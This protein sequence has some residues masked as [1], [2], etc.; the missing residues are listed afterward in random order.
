MQDSL[1]KLSCDLVAIEP[2]GRPDRPSL[3]EEP[4]LNGICMTTQ[5]RAVIEMM[6]NAGEHLDATRF[7]NLRDDANHIDRATVYR[8][9]ELPKTFAADRRTRPDAPAGRKRFL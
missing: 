2:A 5:R 7:V 1:P 3:V 6:Q 8:M 9:I 4:T